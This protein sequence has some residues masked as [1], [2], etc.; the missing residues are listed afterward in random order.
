MKKFKRLVEHVQLQGWT[1][2]RHDKGV[3]AA[4]TLDG[5][6]IEIALSRRGTHG[7]VE[8][9]FRVRAA[10]GD[11][12]S[13]WR[14]MQLPWLVV[15][16]MQIHRLF[17]LTQV[18]DYYQV[19]DDLQ[20]PGEVVITLSCNTAIGSYAYLAVGQEKQTWLVL[21]SGA[22]FKREGE[23]YTQLLPYKLDKSRQESVNNTV[24]RYCKAITESKP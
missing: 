14:I 24:R 9:S 20:G 3:L 21:G 23:R 7:G 5:T 13:I 8:E 17:R 16:K 2:T 15:N 6:T 19:H 1:I 12:T 11:F 18:E 4:R 22:L 10:R